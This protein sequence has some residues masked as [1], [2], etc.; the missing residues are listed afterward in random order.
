MEAIRWALKIVSLRCVIKNTHNF[1]DIEMLLL[2]KKQIAGSR[3]L[4]T[5]MKLETQLFVRHRYDI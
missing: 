5:T 1:F 2:H 4:F 3:R